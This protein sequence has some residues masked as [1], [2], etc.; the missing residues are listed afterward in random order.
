MT[1]DDN[2]E[3]PPCQPFHCQLN[4]VQLHSRLNASLRVRRAVNRC[5]KVFA[6][7]R[8]H[9][10]RH[11]FVSPQRT[12]FSFA[13]LNCKINSPDNY[14]QTMDGDGSGSKQPN[15]QYRR[16]FD[17]LLSRNEATYKVPPIKEMNQGAP[18]HHWNC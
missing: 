15:K 7:Q 9:S 5:S 8:A 4:V 6:E 18:P 3:T 1:N 16:V 12:G 13:T 11:F 2:D 14:H 10:C 17:S